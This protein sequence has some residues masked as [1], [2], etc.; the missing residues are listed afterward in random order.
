LRTA[1]ILAAVAVL[2]GGGFFAWRTFAKAPVAAQG[3]TLLV[4]S[5]PAGVQVVI[6]GV[7]RGM[8][9]AQVSVS[10]GAHILE[11][12]GRGV[13]RVI[14]LNVAAGAQLSQYVE[15]ANTPV[16]G[17]LTIQSE[18][19]GAKVLV[20]GTPRGVAPLT[21]SDLAA[22]SHEVVLE[23]DA[24]S[25][26]HVVDV[27]PGATAS[28]V[29]P[30][31]ALAAGGPVSGWIAVKAPFT[32]EIHEQG[33]L[34]G[35]TDTDRIMLASGRHDLE[36][37]NDTLGFRSSRT[38]QVPPG[39]VAIIAVDLP[40]GVVNLNASPWAEVWI[41]GQRVGE[42]PIGN[43]SVAIG[44]HEVV[45]RNPQLGEKRHAI[46]VTLGAPIRLSVDMK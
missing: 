32:L 35:T 11:L 3:G 46:S 24:G 16:T 7:D 6:D 45:F 21:V 1:A 20:D 12:R 4:Q 13:P 34:L 40:R 26:R 18:P 43:L 25:V 15:F 23:S 8:T 37:V 14:P 39:K 38:V 44:P 2:G 30:M 41:D 19:A 5:S 31:G 29:A 36:L 17:Q 9:P 10:A 33:R 27:Q 22:G 28:L 42:T